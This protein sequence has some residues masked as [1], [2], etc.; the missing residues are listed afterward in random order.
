MVSATRPRFRLFHF[1]ATRSARV[2]WVLHEV[3]DDDFTVEVVPLYEGHQYRP[4]YLARNPNHC[5]PTLEVSFGD[6][7]V[8]NMIESGAMVAWLADVFPA[9][10]L[11]PPADAL[12]AE[13]ADYLQVLHFGTS[14]MDMMLWQIRIHEDLLPAE[15]RDPRTAERYRDKF[16]SEVEPQLRRRLEGGE[17][18]CGPSFS[19][20]DCVIGH[21]VTWARGYGLCQ[22]DAFRRYLSRVSKRPAFVKAFAD[23]REF[24]RQL[25][26]GADPAVVA[27][28][29]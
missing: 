3:V 1:P 4:D 22:D 8:L 25:P 9:R 10:R 19:A 27:F 28:T 2:K 16:A 5:V 21:N 7:T 14:S 20:A 12:S 23:A 15:E 18:I 24:R 26:D 6:G 17:F 13:R 11:A 29:G